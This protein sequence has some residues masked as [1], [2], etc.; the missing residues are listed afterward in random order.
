[1]REATATKEGPRTASTMSGPST[2]SCSECIRITL[3]CPECKTPSCWSLCV[4][5]VYTHTHTH[6]THT[7]NTHT[8]RSAL[9]V[10]WCAVPG[11]LFEKDRFIYWQ[12]AGAQLAAL[13]S[14]NA[15]GAHSQ[16]YCLYMVNLLYMVSVLGAE[17]FQRVRQTF[18]KVLSIVPL[19]GKCTRPLTLE[20]FCAATRS[21]FRA[22]RGSWKAAKF[23]ILVEQLF[24]W[25]AELKPASSSV[26]LAG[27]CVC[28][29]T[30][31]CVCVCARACV[32]VCMCV[33]VCRDPETIARV[34]AS[35]CLDRS[36][37]HYITLHK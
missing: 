32:C 9:G 37:S 3:P 1:M 24:A 25:R 20:N 11:S 10:T 26:P 33:C 18:S 23:E 28:A 19:Q 15:S 17:L 30:C 5:C 22:P 2:K 31:V 27:R 12:T 8:H 13:S 36:C 34:M 4:V 6:N 14:S 29:R 21:P 7:H 16:K 35:D